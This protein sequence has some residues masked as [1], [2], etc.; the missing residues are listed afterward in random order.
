MARNILVVDDALSVR[1][2]VRSTLESD[3]FTIEEAVDGKEAIAKLGQQKFE[4]I[5]TDLN[6]PNLGGMDLLAR[7]KGDRLHK[8]TPV[9]VMTTERSESRKDEARTAGA[10]AWITKPFLPSRLRE[11]VGKLVPQ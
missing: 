11:A 10:R 3:G 7:V 2:L 1:Q 4:L 5:I 8:F 9:L 6:M